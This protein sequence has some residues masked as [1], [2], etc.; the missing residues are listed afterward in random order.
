MGK[1][2]KRIRAGLGMG[3]IWAAGWTPLGLAIGV[4]LG[5]VSGVP[6]GAVAWRL[7]LLFA[8]LG[9]VGGTIFSAVLSITEGRSRFDELSIP[10]F[11]IWGALGGLILGTLVIAPTMLGPGLTALGATFVGACTLIG[12]GSAAGF[13]ALARA[14]D[15]RELL[16]AD[17]EIADAGLTSDESREL[18]GGG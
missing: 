13:L 12:G 2:L 17:A 16:G 10:R 4:A 7:A 1:W 18:L 15:D 3:A 8:G 9:F 5:I 6:I 14:A 11:G